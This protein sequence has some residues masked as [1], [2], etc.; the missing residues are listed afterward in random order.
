MSTL[1]EMDC[2]GETVTIERTDDGDFIFHNWDEETELAAIEL[3]FEPSACLAVWNAINDD[4]LDAELI[5]QSSKGTAL[6]TEAL[7][8]A[9]AS[10]DAKTRTR[11]TPLH[12]AADRGYEDIARVLVDAGASVDA[13]DCDEWTPL[14]NAAMSGHADVAKVLLEAGASVNEQHDAGW[15]PLHEA[16]RWGHTAAT[17]V[18]L[19]AGANVDAKDTAGVTPLKL[20]LY[21]K[22]HD[23]VAVLE[24]W[25]AEHGE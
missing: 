1:F 13:K 18:L 5:E 8:F 15:T 25:I 14:H 2:G 12:Y 4:R 11:W 21:Y 16:A 17:K 6:C 10:V 9:G 20:A 24:S 22:K 7:I 3:G 23:V 19:E